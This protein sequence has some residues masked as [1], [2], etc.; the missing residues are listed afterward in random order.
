MTE[1]P[2]LRGFAAMSRERRIEIATKGGAS[3][4]AEKR[5]FST[6]RD[7]AMDAGR[8]GGLVKKGPKS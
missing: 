7:L 1:T 2:K 8:T 5:A 4:P 6:N 3:V